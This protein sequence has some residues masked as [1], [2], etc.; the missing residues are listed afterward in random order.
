MA[1]GA[2]GNYITYVC[3]FL[4]LLPNNRL[5]HRMSMSSSESSSSDLDT[6]L[7]QHIQKITPAKQN[8]K[9]T[10]PKPKSKSEPTA[11]AVAVAKNEGDDPDWAYAPP[12]GAVLLD[13]TVDVGPFEWDALKDDEDTEMWLIR[14]PDTV[15]L[16]LFSR[17]PPTAD[18]GV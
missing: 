15:R 13:H 9:Q 2:A 16:A 10:K 11:V 7:T 18:T 17:V 12:K 14:V 8:K 4:K 6:N 3:L 1:K 5:R